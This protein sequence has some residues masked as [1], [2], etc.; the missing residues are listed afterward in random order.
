MRRYILV[1]QPNVGKSSLLRALTG[2]QVRVS[3]YPGTTVELYTARAVIGGVE[4]EFVDTP[5]VYNLYPS[6]IEEEVTTRL[7]LSGD[8]DAVILVADAT[9]I[10]R[11]LLLAVELAELGAPMLV[12]VNFW[13][14]AEEKGIIIDY[15]GLE[16]DLGVPVV[17]VNPVRGRLEELLERLGEARRSTLRVRYDDHVED[18]IARAMECTR[19]ARRLDARGLAVRLVEGDPVAL[20]LYGCPAAEEARRRLIEAG[21]DPYNDIEVTRA[22]YALRLAERRVR[23]EARVSK[24]SVIDR[25]MLEKPVAAIAA[26]VAL[27]FAIIAL[28]VVAGGAVAN[29][30]DNLLSPLLERLLTRLKPLGVAGYVASEA[31]IAV[32]AQYTAA[33]PYVVAFYVILAGLEDSGLLARLTLLLHTVSRRLGL[34][35][36]AFIPMMVGLGC[37]V[38]ATIAARVL[39]GMGQRIAAI[40]ALAFI[41]CSSRS[42]IVFGVAGRVAGIAAALG[43]YA[44]GF[45]LALLVA[46]LTARLLGGGEEALL[47]E[48][49][50]PLRR[51]TLSGVALKTWEKLREFILVVTPLVVVGGAVYGL[52][53]ETGVVAASVSILAP[54]ATLLHVPPAA[55]I[56]VFY[57]FI[58]KDLVVSMLAAVLGTPRYWE[59]LSPKQAVT[60]TLAATYQVPCIIA[61]AA[62]VRELGFRRA[63]LLALV[64]DS[65]G[66]LVAIAYANLP[67]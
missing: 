4:Y 1:G 52:L 27:L 50:P 13:E 57:G 53:E 65:L 2:A 59:V 42:S 25:L 63:T 8:Y 45:A 67:V 62:M 54:L 7:V 39:P 22:G 44:L 37:S 61:Y 47:V 43:V 48:D 56:P 29:T 30:L 33:L 32:Y 19:E 31:L 24:P 35:G 12:A 20:E 58:Q 28:V 5:G 17:R 46:S 11:S 15:E 41:P 34:H 23:I 14:E 36:K 51:P 26:A 64:L 60:I 40:A 3:N 18:A 9:A 49:V 38:P 21:H 55:L 6:S 16:E 66:L 10:E